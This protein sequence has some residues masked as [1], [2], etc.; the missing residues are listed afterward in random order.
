MLRQILIS[1][2]A[3]VLPSP[4]LFLPDAEALF[5]DDR[6]LIDQDTRR[7]L[8]D[9]LESLHHWI[10]LHT[11]EPADIPALNGV[12]AKEKHDG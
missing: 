10:R 11:P 7:P 4:T 5:D 12:Q 2:Q 6:R 8:R 9:L 3:L 1:T